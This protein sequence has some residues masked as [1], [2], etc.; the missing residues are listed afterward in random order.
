MSVILSLHIYAVLSVKMCESKKADC[1]LLNHV[2]LTL[3]VLCNCA[4]ACSC[5]CTAEPDSLKD[6]VWEADWI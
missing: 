6:V 1:Y 4:A 5:V 3:H 2:L